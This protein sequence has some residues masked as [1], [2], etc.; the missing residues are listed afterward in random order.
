MTGG[1]DLGVALAA[2]RVLTSRVARYEAGGRR[3]DQEVGGRAESVHE[4]RAAD[5]PKG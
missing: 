3:S 1:P 4:A 2:G 5:Q